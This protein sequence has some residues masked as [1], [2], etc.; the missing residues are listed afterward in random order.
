MPFS[1]VTSNDTSII[2]RANFNPNFSGDIYTSGNVS[3]RLNGYFNTAAFAPS[4]AVGAVSTNVN[5][6]PNQR[7]ICT[8][9]V[10]TVNN[11]FFDPNTPFG[12]V[13][14]N[15]L[16]GPGQ[17]NVDISFIKLVPI[18]ERFRGELRAE[19]AS[20][21]KMFIW[22]SFNRRRRLTRKREFHKS[23]PKL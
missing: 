6:P 1:V 10:G 4:C 13:R 21:R 9:A 8:G 18:S 12:N 17:K 11:P 20:C 5:L 15:F 23:K 22:H 19:K 7:V 2:S 16:T 3:Q 14:R